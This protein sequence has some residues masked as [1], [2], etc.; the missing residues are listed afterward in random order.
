[1]SREEALNMPAAAAAGGCWAASAA[2]RRATYCFCGAACLDRALCCC[3][4]LK[5]LLIVL[6]NNRLLRLQVEKVRVPSWLSGQ[7]LIVVLI[8]AGRGSCACEYMV[9]SLSTA[10]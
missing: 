4:V 2:E 8:W 3:A 5:K 1:M 6:M 7:W 9:V 10:P